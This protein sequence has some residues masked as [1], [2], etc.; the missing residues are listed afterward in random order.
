[1]IAKW[2]NRI[3]LS[4]EEDHWILKINRSKQK[5]INPNDITNNM[6]SKIKTVHSSYLKFKWHLSSYHRRWN[7]Q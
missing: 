3:I 6:Q 1:M 4:I 2:I 5:Q 7:T